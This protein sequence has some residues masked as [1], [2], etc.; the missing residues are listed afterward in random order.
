MRT[1]RALLL[2]SSALLFSQAPFFAVAQAAPQGAPAKVRASARTAAPREKTIGRIERVASFYGPMPTGVTVSHHGRIFVNYPR[3]GDRVPFTVAEVRNGR[4]VPY[5]NRAIFDPKRDRLQRLVSVQSVVVDPLDRLWILD[6]GSVKFGPTLPGGP[7]LVGVDLRTNR[8]F[9]TILF[10]RNVALP[11]T[12]LN[13]VRFDLRRGTQGMAFI[14]DSSGNGPNA[15]IVVDLATGRSWRRLNDHS[16]TKA[17]PKFVPIVEGQALMQRKPGQFPKY[18]TIGADGIAISADG[19]RLYY[20][21][22]ASRKL[23]SVSVDALANE[24]MSDTQVAATVI[25]HGDKGASDG[26]ETD[27]KNRVYCTEYEHNA[28]VRRHPNGLYETVVHDPRVLWP[29]TLSVARNGYLYFTA[30]Q[31]HR[32]PNYHNGKDLRR[33]PYAV[34]RVKIDAGPVLLRR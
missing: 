31:L 6:T 1:H 12:Y 8:V 3:W 20:C 21:P 25:D 18:I 28:I 9:R 5:P 19:E 10:P 29:D 34:Y 17:E 24:T 11:T 15:I 27:N 13:D 7:K 33:K 30:N 22:L 16:S 4:A 14:T 32:Q 23:Y 2:C 26:L